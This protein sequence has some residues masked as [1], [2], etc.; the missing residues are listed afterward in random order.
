MQHARLNTPHFK[1]SSHKRKEPLKALSHG[2]KP[3]FNNK[4]NTSRQVTRAQV[5]LGE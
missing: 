4:K 2:K 1:N 3:A 5:A